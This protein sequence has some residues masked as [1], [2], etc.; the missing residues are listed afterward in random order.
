M[1]YAFTTVAEC[2][3]GM[4]PDIHLRPGWREWS[5]GWTTRLWFH[6]S[7]ADAPF[8]VFCKTDEASI[9]FHAGHRSAA[10]YR[11]ADIFRHEDVETRDQWGYLLP[12]II[13]HRNAFHM[14]DAYDWRIDK[15][16]DRLFEAGL[17]SEREEEAILQMPD[18]LAVFAVLERSGYDAIIYPNQCEGLKGEESILVW[19]AENM[20][21]AHALRFDEGSPC[22]CPSL[23]PEDWE[24]ARW[25]ED[26]D[27]IHDWKVQLLPENLWKLLG[28]EQLPIAA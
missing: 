25:R 9:G 3:G 6:A 4:P 17:L 13:R 27:D 14:P 18:P 2:P 5:D 8:A 7:D 28:E 24:L 22:L 19:R 15:V 21:L 16:T 20:R 11:H 23:I 10:L 1:T 12:L 26:A